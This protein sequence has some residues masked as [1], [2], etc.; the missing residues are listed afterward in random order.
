MS[1][2]FH[3]LPKEILGLIVASDLSV[4]SK[5]ILKL[6][7]SYPDLQDKIVTNFLYAQDPALYR[8]LSLTGTNV[9]KKFL[10]LI[11]YIINE[12]DVND[13]NYMNRLYYLLDNINN[14]LE[15]YD[16]INYA[17][18]LGHDHKKL[19]NI[20]IK[21][22]FQK[23]FPSILEYYYRNIKKMDFNLHELYRSLRSINDTPIRF[24]R[25]SE[26]VI[27]D[28]L[29]LWEIDN[30]KRKRISDIYISERTRYELYDNGAHDNLIKLLKN[31]GVK[32]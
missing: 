7:N 16:V 2:Y 25:I 20:I 8:S 21:I 11:K 22:L 14:S 9:S 5:V 29:E 30:P 26:D 32:L 13:N 3:C 1:S 31:A 10:K 27:I 24:F 23:N 4:K 19:F 17:K 15:S 6:V 28:I 18:I 12:Y